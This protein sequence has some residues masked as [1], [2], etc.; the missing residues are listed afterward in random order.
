M[1][2]VGL[3]EVLSNAGV[4]RYLILKQDVSSEE[5]DSGWTL[6]LSLR[7]LSVSCLIIF[8]E[9]LAIFINFPEARGLII[10]L[11]LI[12]MLDSFRSI[13]LLKKEKE[14]NFSTFNK[15]L[16]TAKLVSVAVTITAALL[17]QDYRA[18]VLGTL[19]N[20]LSITLLSYLICG[21]RPRFCFKFDRKMLSFSSFLMLRSI[22]SYSRSQ[23]DVLLVGN[24]YGPS[25]VGNYKVT[26][27]MVLIP[28][29]EIIDAAFRPLLST[30]S[31]AK[32]CEIKPLLYKILTYFSMI[33]SPFC[34]FFFYNSNDFV[35]FFLGNN[36]TD[37][38]EIFQYL[39]FI[40]LP[41]SFQVLIL[42]IF[43]RLGKI[44]RS[45]IFDLLAIFYI[46]SAFLYL[47][48]STIQHF[49]EIRVIIAFISLA[50]MVLIAS[51]ILR[52][53]IVAFL[54]TSLFPFLVSMVIA[55]LANAI[56]SKLEV[57]HS[58]VSIII[59]TFIFT[60]LYFAV[61]TLIFRTSEKVRSYPIIGDINKDINKLSMM[62]L[63]RK[64]S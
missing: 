4:M 47:S 57:G 35:L 30:L 20:S 34:F 52:V 9:Q 60:T 39:G 18:L 50:S 37:T 58:L 32:D 26:L 59:Y 29:S 17:I 42:I 7:A 23:L 3:F 28:K 21:G 55:F 33:L 41:I 25:A 5:Y 62:V 15:I 45:F 40:V 24:K 1:M 22:I 10:S 44:K 14:L 46:V 63:R 61:M 31:K 6:N 2:V 64:K 53:N 8:S 36:W 43:D 56:N 27:D 13:E 54:I 38:I 49:V 11:S 19:A 12:Q 16:I 48:P 51:Y